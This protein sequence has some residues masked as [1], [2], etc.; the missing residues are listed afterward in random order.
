M[1]TDSQ[2]MQIYPLPIM[3]GGKEV[4][5][6]LNYT[7]VFNP[8]VIR[9]TPVDNAGIKQYDYDTVIDEFLSKFETWVI[10]CEY[11]SSDVEHYH[12]Y[13][14]D[15]CDHATM[16]QNVRDFIY[17]F[18]PN[19]TRGFGGKQSNCQIS[20][21][22]LEAIMYALKHRGK[23][24]WSGFNEEFINKCIA[25]SFVI[26]ESKIDVEIAKLSEVFLKTKMDPYEFSEKLC[27]LYAEH[28]KRIHFKDIQGYV[29]S[30]IIKRD[31]TMAHSMV[32]KNLQF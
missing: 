28:D 26:P 29:N 22:P 8:Y 6:G 1:T 27:V 31:P 32:R 30:K 15:P 5:G 2:I 19:R 18:F 7:P 24:H 20:E 10:S 12:I 11:S 13:V 17:P 3:V 16:K 21:K 14:E 23:H 25:S 9:L 4:T